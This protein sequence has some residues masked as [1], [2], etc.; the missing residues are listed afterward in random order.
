MDDNDEPDDGLSGDDDATEFED[1][2]ALVSGD[3]PDESGAVTDGTTVVA[4]TAAVSTNPVRADTDQV[5]VAPPPS[6]AASAA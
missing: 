6:R 5:P 1:L 4:V 3:E 2:A